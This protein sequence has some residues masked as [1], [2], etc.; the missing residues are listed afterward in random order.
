M[1]TYKEIRG[2]TIQVVDSDPTAQVGEIFYNNSSRTMKAF[3]VG[4]ASWASG[5]N[6]GTA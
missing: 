2:K 3:N 5:G 6:L 4:A 1:T